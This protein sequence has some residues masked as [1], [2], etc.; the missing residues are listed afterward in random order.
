MFWRR[1]LDLSYRP[2]IGLAAARIEVRALS[3]ACN[4]SADVKWKRIC[5]F[6]L[7][8]TLPGKCPGHLIQKDFKNVK[9]SIFSHKEH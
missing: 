5:A 7:K 8:R 2:P 9:P 6:K 4:R 1:D 3:V